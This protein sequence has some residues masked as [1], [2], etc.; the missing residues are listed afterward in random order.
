VLDVGALGV[1]FSA[2]EPLAFHA[3]ND[4]EPLV[5][6]GRSLQWKDFTQQL[7]EI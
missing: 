2:F 6:L 4:A 3:K 1:F 7:A 5:S